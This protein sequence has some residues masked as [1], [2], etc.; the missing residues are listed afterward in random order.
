MLKENATLAFKNCDESLKIDIKGEIDH[1][2][3]KKLRENIDSALFMY[4]PKLLELNLKSVTF[5]DSSGLGLIVGRL[6][7]AETLGC[8]VRLENVK[9]DVMKILKL[10]G[11]D[12]ISRLEIEMAKEQKR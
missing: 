7:T 8:H 5:M 6:D 9:R 11:V 10:A 1:H 12:K 4:R 2:S 3:A